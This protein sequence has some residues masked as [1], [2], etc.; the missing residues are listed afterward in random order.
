MAF[1]FRMSQEGITGGYG[2]FMKMR[3]FDSE[4]LSGDDAG[5]QG[6]LE[7]A[8]N[9]AN[10]LIVADLHLVKGIDSA[11]TGILIR[12]AKLARKH[13]GHFELDG[14]RDGIRANLKVMNILPLFHKVNS[15]VVPEEETTDQ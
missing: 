4:V 2:D 5:L 11:A 15:L 9:P 10:N 6:L 1:N 14:V 8:Q 3:T 13:G 12:I 7:D